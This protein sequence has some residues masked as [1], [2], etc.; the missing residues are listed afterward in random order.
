MMGGEN[1]KEKGREGE[2]GMIS[3]GEKYRTIS[4]ELKVQN[5]IGIFFAPDVLSL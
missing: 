3:T 5:Y 4:T 2:G 1:W